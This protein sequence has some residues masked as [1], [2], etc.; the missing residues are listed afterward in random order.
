MGPGASTI[1][2]IGGILGFL[3]KGGEARRV[4]ERD[5]SDGREVVVAK[6]TET[7]RE[8]GAGFVFRVHCRAHERRGVFI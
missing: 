3:E 4:R 2:T 8:S 1:E 6:E 5:E 7:E